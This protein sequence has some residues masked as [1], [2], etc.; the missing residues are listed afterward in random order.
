MFF[1]SSEIL[2]GGLKINKMQF[3][4]PESHPDPDSRKSGIRIP[5]DSV[6]MDSHQGDGKRSGRIGNFL[7]KET[8]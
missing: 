8:A 2:H 4:K 1:Y 5:M 6:N 7:G 3:D